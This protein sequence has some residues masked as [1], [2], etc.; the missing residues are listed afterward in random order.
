MDFGDRRHHVVDELRDVDALRG[1]RFRCALPALE[2]DQLIDQR[3]HRQTL[4]VDR[5]QDAFVIAGLAQVSLA[6]NRGEAA[7]D[8]QRRAQL[9]ARI[10][11]ELAHAGLRAVA[12]G[13]RMRHLLDRAVVRARQRVEPVA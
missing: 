2:Q 6:Q 7:D 3:A 9:M 5:I 12:L 10:G 13:E 1:N 8:G 4:P 11:D